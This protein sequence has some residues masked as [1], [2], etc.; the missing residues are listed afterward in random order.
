MRLSRDGHVAALSGAGGRVAGGPLSRR[1]VI[2]RFAPIA[3]GATRPRVADD[4][5]LLI[6]T[7]LLSE[8]VNLQDAGLVIHLDMPWTPARIEQRLGR[9]T[10]VGSRHERVLSFAFRPPASADVIIRMERILRRKLENAGLVVESLPSLIEWTTGRET[11]GGPP[12][13]AELLLNLIGS[14]KDSRKTVA[15]SRVAVA[16]VHASSDGF[17]AALEAGHDVRLVGCMG[18][19]ISDD[20]AFTL[21]CARLATGSDAECLP[22]QAVRCET[23]L[24][25]WIDSNEAL[26][27]ARE[28]SSSRSTPRNKAAR[29]IARAVRNARLHERSEIIDAAQAARTA[30]GAS[31]GVHGDTEL[32]A[33]CESDESDVTWLH[34]VAA[35]GT[36]VSLP[37][38]SMPRHGVRLVAMILFVATKPE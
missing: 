2:G 11:P 38:V 4:V 36:R 12:L 6:T 13:N 19:P 25:R 18:G 1:E 10:R 16:A 17:V 14:W 21:G 31:F 22:A 5:T 23:D 32:S 26:R 28:S 8:G 7:D 35:L 33:L 3:S 9:V 20:V 37:V 15:N 30:L 27:G 29:R 24:I 34:R